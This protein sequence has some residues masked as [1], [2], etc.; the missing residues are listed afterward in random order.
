MWFLGKYQPK[1]II[2]HL[3]QS[4]LQ[5][6]LHAICSSIFLSEY[7]CFCGL[8]L[9]AKTYK[10]N[11]VLKKWVASAKMFISNKDCQ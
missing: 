10:V 11:L 2:I 5:L 6:M 1:W 9:I 3:I 4:Y 7:V 8:D